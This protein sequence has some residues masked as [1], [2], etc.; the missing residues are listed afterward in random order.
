M[1]KVYVVNGSTNLYD[2][3]INFNTASVH[4]TMNGAA[5]G[6]RAEIE[7]RCIALK[8]NFMEQFSD[9]NYA[10]DF[11]GYDSFDEFWEDWIKDYTCTPTYWCYNTDVLSITVYIK[12]IELS[13]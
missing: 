6:L 11:D 10:E 12:E 2:D 1:N 7:N 8:E 13:N 9:E 4:T 3:D 5:K